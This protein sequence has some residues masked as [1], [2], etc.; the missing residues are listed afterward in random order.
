MIVSFNFVNFIVVIFY[1]K[2]IGSCYQK[3]KN[4]A[5]NADS[6]LGYRFQRVR[7]KTVDRSEWNFGTGYTSGRRAGVS[8]TWTRNKRV[9]RRFAF[10]PDAHGTR[11]SSHQ[12][13]V[14][15]VYSVSR[16][17]SRCCSSGTPTWPKIRFHRDNGPLSVRYLSVT[18]RQMTWRDLDQRYVEE[19]LS[20]GSCCVRSILKD[21]MVFRRIPYRK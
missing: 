16:T 12:T 15:R 14:S 3:K 6:L 11:G 10:K 20:V 9:E 8:K 17:C 19:A 21:A 7:H 1:W 13:L 2:F 18:A 4:R 5:Q